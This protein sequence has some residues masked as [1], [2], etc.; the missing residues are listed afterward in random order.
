MPLRARVNTPDELGSA[1]REFRMRAKLTQVSVRDGLAIAASDRG[2]APAR[3]R[4][5]A[6]PA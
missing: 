4:G 6:A 5:A 2:G 3:V 1:L